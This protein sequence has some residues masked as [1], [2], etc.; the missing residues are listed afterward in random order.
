MVNQ[1]KDVQFLTWFLWISVKF[2]ALVNCV[3]ISKKVQICSSHLLVFNVTLWIQI[4]RKTILFGMMQ[5]VKAIVTSVLSEQEHLCLAYTGCPRR[6]V[7]YLGR[8]FLMLN[9]TNI[10]QNTYIQRWM[11]TEI[12][13]IEKCGLLGSRRTV[14]VRDAILVHCPCWQRDNTS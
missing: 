12:M 7:K 10:T 2:G 4:Q 1:Q 9:Y 11:V 8:V 13:T 14:A 3:D 5:L 6:N